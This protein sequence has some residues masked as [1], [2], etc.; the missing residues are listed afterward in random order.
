MQIAICPACQHGLT[1]A[2]K[3]KGYINLPA[4]HEYKVHMRKLS[5]LQRTATSGCPL[6]T[7]LLRCVMRTADVQTPAEELNLVLG[8]VRR[9]IGLIYDIMNTG[10]GSTR[11]YY[12]PTPELQIVPTKGRKS[13]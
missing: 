8:R 1:D 9:M 4:I 6:C 5:H 13:N 7:I 2:E 3:S 10:L 11:S 12:A